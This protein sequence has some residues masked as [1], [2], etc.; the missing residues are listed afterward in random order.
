[1]R[2]TLGGPRSLSSRL[3]GRNGFH[4][5]ATKPRS[6][7]PTK[8]RPG[9]PQHG[10]AEQL[11]EVPSS[12]EE[13]GQAGGAGQQQEPKEYAQPQPGGEESLEQAVLAG[14]DA[15]E[16]PEAGASAD[17]VQKAAEGRADGGRRRCRRRKRKRGAQPPA[18]CA[19]APSAGEAK[20]DEGR[21]QEEAAQA[22]L[23]DQQEAQQ[24]ER[25]QMESDVED[26]EPRD[27]VQPGDTAAP[28]AD[29]PEAL[30]LQPAH[31][32][33]PSTPWADDDDLELD[34]PAAPRHPA[35]P[36]DSEL[37]GSGGDSDWDYGRQGDWEYGRQGDPQTSVRLPP[38]SPRYGG[39]WIC[40]HCNVHN[41]EARDSCGNPHCVMARSPREGAPLG[42]EM[43]GVTQRAATPQ[44]GERACMGGQ[45]TQHPPE[46]FRAPAAGYDIADSGW[47]AAPK[48]GTV[49]TGYSQH[50]H[51]HQPQGFGE[52]WMRQQDMQFGAQG[53]DH[54]AHTGGA[55]P[56]LP[57]QP[58][59]G[60]PLQ[61]TELPPLPLQQ[62]GMQWQ[63]TPP[64]LQQPP[65]EIQQPHQYN[66][67]VTLVPVGPVR[68]PPPPVDERSAWSGLY[69]QGA[70]I[71][72]AHADQLTGIVPERGVD[73][74]RQVLSSPELS[75]LPV[76]ES[77]GNFAS[78]G[79][80]QSTASPP[81]SVRAQAAPRADRPP[82][83]PSAVRRRV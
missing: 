74:A 16:C 12:K 66:L 67:P 10:E 2:R 28:H 34:L 80:V 76:Y 4:T 79:A 8:T 46:H 5:C 60:Q 33:R 26:S 58:M 15:V 63:R 43:P 13:G 55:V 45:F 50:T 44:S 42:V 36:A 27:E 57:P 14:T 37:D 41:F 49:Q 56:P 22:P 9:E 70:Q 23:G 53:A 69:G 73:C 3:S 52:P 51:A 75:P 64:Q 62:P 25:E 18:A 30:E 65:P 20:A 21:S 24:D 72:P 29:P 11:Q 82:Y 61:Q 31:G 81:V 78:A 1:M 39:R 71:C 40:Q 54:Q 83:I 35:Q 32:A 17:P 19:K 7:V 47:I 59:Q 38:D 6:R 48:W 68:Y 77:W